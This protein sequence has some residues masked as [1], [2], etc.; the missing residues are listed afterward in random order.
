[1]PRALAHRKNKKFLPSQ[2][3]DRSD[4]KK[5]CGFAALRLCVKSNFKSLPSFS[6][7]SSKHSEERTWADR[8]RVHAKTPSRKAAICLIF[9][10]MPRALAHRKNYKI[11]S[12][13]ERRSLG[14]QEKLRLCGLAAL[15]E[16]QLKSELPSFSAS[17]SKHLRRGLGPTV[18]GS[19]KDAKPQSR[20]LPH[21]PGHASCPG[22]S[23]K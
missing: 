14:Q 3:A 5:N 9:R 4:S 13:S 16:I 7:S 23:K 21:L 20:N 10:A 1:M 6:A 18:E 22:P 17:S 11:S 2:S 12:F 8:R 15:R 19:R